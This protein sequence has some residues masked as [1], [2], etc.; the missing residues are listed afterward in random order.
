MESGSCFC[1]EEFTQ[2]DSCCQSGKS[3]VF[4]PHVRKTHIIF[5]FYCL[6]CCLDIRLTKPETTAYVSEDTVRSVSVAGRCL[7][8]TS[9]GRDSA[10]QLTANT[11]LI[12]HSAD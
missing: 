3:G 1:A 12:Y 11:K 8:E 4:F 2:T 7:T 10:Y 5:D 6:C 9:G